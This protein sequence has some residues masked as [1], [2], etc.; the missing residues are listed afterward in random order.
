M[1]KYQQA[2]IFYNKYVRLNDIK[3]EEFSRLTNKLLSYNYICASRPRDL[4][5]YYKIIADLDLYVSYFALM[6]YVLENHS[7][8][9]VVNLYNL[10][11]Y[12][13]YS[14]K[15]NE[16]V[17]LLLLRKFYYQKM[18]EISLLDD[19][20]ITLQQLHDAIN[21]TGIFGK[22]INKSELK[23]V[24]RVLKRYNIIDLTGNSDDD[25][26]VIIIYPTILYVLPVE[27]LEEIDNILADYQKRGDISEET[28]QDEDN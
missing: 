17:I 21:T 13:R 16:S 7:V 2:T 20:T 18:Q 23:E 12:N 25:N 10:Q 11:N 1:D 28:S 26:A 9:K 14:F 3:K 15:K 22:R 19:I 4:D 8:D 27:R 24:F 5:D 6:D